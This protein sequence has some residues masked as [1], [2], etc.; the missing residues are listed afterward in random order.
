ML[1]KC[2]ITYQKNIE[3]GKIR[4]L[5]IDRGNSYQLCFSFEKLEINLENIKQFKNSK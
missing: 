1:Y 5:S 3:K 4:L 2:K